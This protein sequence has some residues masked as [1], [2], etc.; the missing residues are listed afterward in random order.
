MLLQQ[1]AFVDRDGNFSREA[2]VNFVQGIDNDETG[3]MAAYW[4]FLEETVYRNQLYNKYGSL[5][6]NS[7]FQTSA[8]AT[9]P[10]IR[11]GI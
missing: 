6:E 5:I 3:N 10:P 8:T 4:S 9:D 11:L 7:C 2:L 1:G